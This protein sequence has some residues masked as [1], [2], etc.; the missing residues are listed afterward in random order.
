[1]GSSRRTDLNVV[2]LVTNWWMGGVS[3]FLA[4]L[5]SGLAAQGVN[6]RVLATVGEQNDLTLPPP[7][8]FPFEIA[9]WRN[10]RSWRIRWKAMIAYL[11]ALAPCVF[12]PGYDQAYSCVS[13]KLSN[14]VVIVGNIHSDH[15]EA[16]EHF[17]RLGRY[18]NQT[19]MGSEYL[20]LKV[21]A[22]YP[23]L[24]DR[25]SVLPYGVVIPP[26]RPVRNRIAGDPLRILY[27]GRLTQ[28]GKRVLDVPRIVD[29]LVRRQV[30]VQL[31]FTGR[32]QDEEA[33]RA[34]C[35]HLSDRGMVQFYGMVA[36]ERLP[37]IYE[38]ND[39]LILPSEFEGKPLGLVEGMGRGCVPVATDIPS[40]IP[41]LVKDGVNGYLVPVGAIETFADRLTDLHRDMRLWE[42]FS[43]SAFE[44]VSRGGYRVEDMVAGYLELFRR[45]T[46]EAAAGQFRRRRGRILLPPLPL[47]S[48][49]ASMQPTWK[50]LLPEPVR[51]AGKRCWA[52]LRWAYHR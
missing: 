50:D 45:L 28:E 12:L 40:G 52:A 36:E 24:A 23:G 30:P 5:V 42:R 27:T 7:S 22:Q 47:L 33:L 25:L 32:G 15:S 37:G 49:P 31:S 38:Q 41:E 44:T 20:R 34:A 43:A 35:Q 1:L 19:V 8:G 14:H 11:E 48:H 4:G 21:A 39:I 3:N 16:Y 6:A 10:E 2:A 51:T 46:R 26:A 17:G 18:W 9:P 29:A 13:P